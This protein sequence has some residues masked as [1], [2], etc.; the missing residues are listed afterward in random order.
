[1]GKFLA[2][3]LL[4]PHMFPNDPFGNV[5]KDTVS[6]G[7]GDEYAALH[8]IMRS[9]HPNLIE[10][11][12]ET[13]TPYQGNMVTLAA[14]VRN[15]SN[16]MEKEAMRKRYYKE[17]ESLMMVVE[18]LHG[19]C[20]EGLKQKVELSFTTKHDR[21]NKIPFKLEMANLGTTLTEWEDE[22]K[23][24]VSQGTREGVHHINIGSHVRYSAPEDPLDYVNVI[25]SVQTCSVFSTGGHT[26]DDC[27]LFINAV[28]C[29][30]VI[31]SHPDV[32]GVICKSHKTFFHHKPRP[33][34]PRV[35]TIMYDQPAEEA[36]VTHDDS[37]SLKF[38][39]DDYIY[40][41]HNSSAAAQGGDDSTPG[42]IDP[43]GGSMVHFH[44]CR[45]TLWSHTGGSDPM[46]CP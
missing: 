2:K 42:D 31:K 26:L 1:M 40:H 35:H 25:D 14:H 44:Q 6:N 3:I 5:M 17:Y 30:D 37:P 34:G 7:E 23:V 33:R 11:A 36:P 38:D 19:R 28:K 4:N 10:K 16:H 21:V 18:S 27:H 22:L 41:F 46:Q 15:M 43:F 12:V 45:P 13:I 9:V 32:A 8:N 29:Q 24:G 39:A 20:H